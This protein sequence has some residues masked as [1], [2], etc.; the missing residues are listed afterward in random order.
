MA[1]GHW[2]YIHM[3]IFLYQFLVQCDMIQSPLKS[4]QKFKYKKKYV[5]ENI[6]F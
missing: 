5:G 1:F 4:Q 3:E 2:D 6:Y